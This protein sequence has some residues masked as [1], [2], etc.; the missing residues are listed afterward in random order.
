MTRGFLVS[1]VQLFVFDVNL[2]AHTISGLASFNDLSPDTKLDDLSPDTK[3]QIPLLH[4]TLHHH[5]SVFSS[6]TI[7]WDVP[8]VRDV[9]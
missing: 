7:R 8:Y 1:D 5:V 2:D 4:G 9:N 3:L 6:S